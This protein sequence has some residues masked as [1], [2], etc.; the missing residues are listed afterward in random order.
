MGVGGA[1][2]ALD[3]A[4]AARVPEAGLGDAAPARARLTSTGTTALADLLGVRMA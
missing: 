4:L 1:A 2:G 3:A